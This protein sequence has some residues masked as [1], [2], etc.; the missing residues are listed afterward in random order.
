MVTGF[1]PR[2][3]IYGD[4]D[5][6]H[7]QSED[8][9]FGVGED[10]EDTGYSF[11]LRYAVPGTARAKPFLRIGGL[12]KHVE[13]EDNDG[14]LVADSKHTGRGWEAG[15]GLDVRLNDSWSLT[16]GVRYRRFEPTVRFGGTETSTTLAYV[17]FDVGIALKF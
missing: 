3:T 11:G 4:W 14:S 6:H 17:M 5:W 16:P 1:F 10:V 2:L 8:L 9:L 15:G 13:I 12:Y 7:R